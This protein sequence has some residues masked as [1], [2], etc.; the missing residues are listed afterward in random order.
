MQHILTVHHFGQLLGGCS[1]IELMKLWN[2]NLY[3]KVYMY[4]H[5]DRSAHHTTPSETP[6]P[7]VLSLGGF[8]R[9]HIFLNKSLPPLT[10]LSRRLARPHDLILEHVAR[11]ASPSP[12]REDWRLPG[13]CACSNRLRIQLLQ[14]ACAN[15]E[16]HR[17]NR[18]VANYPQVVR[19]TIQW[20]KTKI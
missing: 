1:M 20:L 19:F 18:H 12:L 16:R 10:E 6:W 13:A 15:V 3:S 11:H 4:S 9:K 17:F 2:G 7:I 14:A 5:T 8:S